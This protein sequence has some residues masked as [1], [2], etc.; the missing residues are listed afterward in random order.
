[1]LKS[2]EDLHVSQIVHK[3]FIDVNEEGTE[4]AAATGKCSFSATSSYLGSIPIPHPARAPSLFLPFALRY[5]IFSMVLPLLTSF[6]LLKFIAT[7]LI[8]LCSHC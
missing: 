1:M 4:A 5:P 8:I 2:P 6:L 3:A 7:V